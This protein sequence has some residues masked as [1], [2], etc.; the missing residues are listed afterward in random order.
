MRLI[1]KRKL[2]KTLTDFELTDS[3]VSYNNR[4][5]L[6]KELILVYIYEPNNGILKFTLLDDYIR[7]HY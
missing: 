6:D 2:T 4:A 1:T 5:L 3:I 7:L